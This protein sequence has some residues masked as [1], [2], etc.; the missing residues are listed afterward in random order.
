VTYRFAGSYENQVRSEKTLALVLP[1]ALFLIFLVL[2]FQFRKVT[3]T[4]LVF[5][6]IIACWAGGFTLIWLFGQSWFFDVSLFGSNLRDIFNMHTINLS[7]A[8][9]VG[10][11]AL[12]GIAS[13]DGVIMC[14]YLEQRFSGV[15][16][17]SIAEIRSMVVEG[18]VRRVRPAL[19]TSATTILALLPI[20]TATGRGA[21]IMIP[22]AIPSFGG[23]LIELTIIFQA[24][25]LYCMWKERQLRRQGRTA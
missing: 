16:P 15:K 4:S 13:D 18:A 3:V 6:G 10:F 20:L 9:W 14:T 25:I 7:V 2:Y 21:D 5:L 1:L 17:A 24:P 11:L 23:M 8:I 12:F 22:M 19:M